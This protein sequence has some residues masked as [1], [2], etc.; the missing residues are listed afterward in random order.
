MIE[1]ERSGREDRA[2]KSGRNEIVISRLQTWV[3]TREVRERAPGQ[4]L[5]LIFI[6]NFI[7]I[8]P[9]G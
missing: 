2:G 7:A 1:Y 8:A 5:R 4:R 3:V 6:R 9:T